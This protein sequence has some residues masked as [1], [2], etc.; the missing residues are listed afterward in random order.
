MYMSSYLRVE[1]RINENFIP[2]QIC[3]IS[4]FHYLIIVYPIIT[5]PVTDLFADRQ[6]KRYSDRNLLHL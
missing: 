3:R 4:H 1:I 2:P 5:L 6:I